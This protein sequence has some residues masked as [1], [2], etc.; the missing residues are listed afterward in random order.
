MALKN[1]FE[2]L[3]RCKSLKI[4]YFFLWVSAMGGFLFTFTGTRRRPEL[5][6]II[7]D[8]LQLN[9]YRSNIHFPRSVLSEPS[10][11]ELLH[12]KDFK[13]VY[14]STKICRE[15][16]PFILVLVHTAPNHFIHRKLIRNTWGSI[17][18]IH[19]VTISIGFLL[20]ETDQRL[21]SRIRQEKDQHHDIIQGS[22]VDSYRNLSLKHIMGYKWA[23]EFCPKA[24]F[25]LKLDDDVYVDTFQIVRFLLFTFGRS[26]TSVLACSVVSAGTLP[27]RNGKWGV[28]RKEFSFDTY[29]E[30]CSGM[31]YFVTLDIARDILAA[32]KRLPFFWVDDIFV[33]GIVAE[34][35]DLSRLPINAHTSDR[36]E[37]MINWLKQGKGPSP[38]IYITWMCYT[39]IMYNDSEAERNIDERSDLQL[40]RE[41]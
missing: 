37:D 12:L 14:N 9:E 41:L 35:L 15:K 31:G 19:N 24:T 22:F 21:Q 27:H 5:P 13:F 6:N 3:L 30:Y 28:T 23:T 32:S 20:G 38:Y 8:T 39:M 25:I 16:P 1:I 40:C 7:G 18:H 26:P 34:A 33:T 29:P 11:M 10:P 2:D 17:R 4:R 36:P